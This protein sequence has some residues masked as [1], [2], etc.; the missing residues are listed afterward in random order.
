MIRQK[1]RDVQKIIK[2]RKKS[3]ISVEIKKKRAEDGI[4]EGKNK[5]E[6]NSKMIVMIIEL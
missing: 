1:E 5:T 2:Q 6:K 3:G 4:S